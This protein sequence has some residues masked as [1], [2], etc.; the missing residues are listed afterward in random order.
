AGDDPVRTANGPAAVPGGDGAGNG[1]AGDLPGAGAPVAAERDR[2]A[3]PGD[4]LPEVPLQGAGAPLRHGRR[5]GGRSRPL[6]ARRGHRGA[7]GAVA[8]A[9]GPAD[10]QA[11]DLLGGSRSRDA[12][13]GRPGW[14]RVVADL[15]AGGGRAGGRSR[16]GRHGAGRGR[17]P[18]RDGPGAER[19]VVAGGPR[20]AGAGEGPAG[21]P[22]GGRGPARGWRG[23]GAGGATAG[24]RSCAAGWTR[25]PATWT[26]PPGWK[27]SV[28]I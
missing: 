11:A 19:V 6:P 27:R 13:R 3:R 10:P 5:A 12:G 2:P 4:R 15:R 18:A 24:R 21:L 20:R 16:A 17:G 28:W 7:A 9:A 22:R 23:G 14:R 8:G 26:W 1:A 25:V